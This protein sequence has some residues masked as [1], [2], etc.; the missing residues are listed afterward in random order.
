MTLWAIVCRSATVLNGSY[1]HSR[2]RI[3]K[4]RAQ[5]VTFGARGND[6]SRRAFD[7]LHGARHINARHGNG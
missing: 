1:L 5:H 6:H 7:F 4:L 2:R 3:A